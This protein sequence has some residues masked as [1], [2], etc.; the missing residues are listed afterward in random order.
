VEYSSCSQF[1]SCSLHQV[2][3]EKFTIVFSH[4]QCTILLICVYNHRLVDVTFMQFCLPLSNLFNFPQM[5]LYSNFVAT[6]PINFCCY[7][8]NLYN[9]CWLLPICITWVQQF[10]TAWLGHYGHMKPN[11]FFSL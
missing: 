5:V 6:T 8:T 7:N 9:C 10:S 4:C 1:D 2:H 11:R 3:F